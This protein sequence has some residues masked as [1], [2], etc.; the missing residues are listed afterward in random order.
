[1]PDLMTLLANVGSQITPI[2]M[3]LQAIAAL[4]GV[5]MTAS[6]LIEFFGVSNP[7]SLKYV[8]G[9]DRFSVT[10]GITQLL[11]GAI[12]IS[13]STLE[14]VGIMSRTL[15][16]D[17]ANSRFLSYTAQTST[18]DE[19]RMAALAT[20]LGIMQIVGFVAMVKGWMTL[21]DIAHQKTQA[22]KGVA[23][24]WMIGGIC[25]WNF[26]WVTDVINCTFGYNVIGLFTPYGMA[27]AC[28]AAF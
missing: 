5:Y 14:M 20:I 16:D 8:S 19:Q 11:I 10:G 26:K 22:S 2:I 15:T 18:F 24:G 1:M 7:N 9:R 28:K 12:L 21:N 27:N 17:Y 3:M 25:A 13:M 4:M 23:F 6:A